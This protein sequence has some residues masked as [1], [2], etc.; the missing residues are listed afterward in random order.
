MLGLT[1][2]QGIIVAIGGAIF[3]AVAAAVLFVR[4]RR[5]PETPDIPRGM[6]PGPSDADLETPL[7][8]KL[9]GWGVLL[10]VFLVIWVPATWLFEPSVNLGQERALSEDAIHRGSLAVELFSEENQG[11]VGCVQCHGPTL[12]GGRVLNP[13]TQTP[14]PTPNL[15]TVCGG[16]WTGHPAIHGLDDIYTTIEQGRGRIMPSWSIRFAGALNDQQINDIVTYIVSIQDE[17]QVPFEQ[18]VCINPE[19]E[20]LADEE[21]PDKPPATDNPETQL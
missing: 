13:E 3:L 19:A 10:I 11:G 8:Q 5:R 1:Q 16:P 18:N 6:R 14:I 17:E 21:F 20:T 2:A 7:L 12:E 9:Q 4:G 15:R